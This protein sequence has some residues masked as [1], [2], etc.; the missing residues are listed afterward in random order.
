MNENIL[1]MFCVVCFLYVIGSLFYG[2]YLNLVK[3]DDIYERTQDLKKT[4]IFDRFCEDRGSTLVDSS[5]YG[6]WIRCATNQTIKQYE[7]NYIN[8]RFLE[9]I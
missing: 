3:V 1:F 2:I 8:G 7:V 4:D 9:S 5:N 6:Y